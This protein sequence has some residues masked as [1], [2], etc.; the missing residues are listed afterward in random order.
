MLM[1]WERAILLIDNEMVITM[2]GNPSLKVNRN[3]WLSNTAD[4]KTTGVDTCPAG[5]KSQC[6]ALVLV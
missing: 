6:G 4:S 2:A 3:T 5:G 1:G